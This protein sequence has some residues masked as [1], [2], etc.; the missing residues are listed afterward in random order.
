[1]L[2]MLRA[3][4]RPLRVPDDKAP[5]DAQE[6]RDFRRLI[7]AWQDKSATRAVAGQER[8]AE[9]LARWAARS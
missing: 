2:T 4:L 8:H 7:H 1:M 3:R 5:L 6:L 9:L